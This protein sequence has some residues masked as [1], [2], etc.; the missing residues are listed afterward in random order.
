MPSSAEG[1][2]GSRGAGR[3]WAALSATLA[4]GACVAFAID[5][6]TA[7]DW[8]PALA[9]RQPWRGWTAVWVHYSALHLEANLAGCALVAALGMVA[10]VPRRTVAAWF[11]AWPLTQ[12]GLLLRPDLLHYGG[13]SGVLHAGVAAVAFY[14]I[15]AAGGTRRLV[16][17]GL[18]AGLAVK[19]GIEAPWDEALR[20]PVGWDI[21]VAPFAHASG[22][23]AGA[24]MAAFVEAFRRRPRTIGRDD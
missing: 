2:A 14:L 13:L 24:A 23:V 7:I 22:L 12:F 3:A 8:Q 6:P 20:H 18:L 21:A 4:I 11:I 16:G 17:I 1:S 15:V 19:V 10:R 5:A 9:A